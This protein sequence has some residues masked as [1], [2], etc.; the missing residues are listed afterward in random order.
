MK[1]LRTK[2]FFSVGT[3]LLLSSIINTIVSELW[4]RKELGRGGARISHYM[5]NAQNQAK[6]FASFLLSFRIIEQAADLERV[7]EMTSSSLSIE[8]TSTWLEAEKPLSYDPDIAF[9]QVQTKN[10][11]NAVIT[12][13]DAKL[14]PFSWAQG[15]DTTLWIK[16]PEEEGL[17]VGVPE[18]KGEETIYLLFEH[19]LL[20]KHLSSLSSSLLL[21]A[22][23]S[24]EDAAFKEINVPSFSYNWKDSVSHLFSSLLLYQ[25][26]WLE[27]LNLI[28]SLIP[29][30][31]IQEAVVPY[32]IAKIP[33]LDKHPGQHPGGCLLRKEL[34]STES[35]ILDIESKEQEKVPFL[36]LRNTP[37]GKD[38]DM[39]KAVLFS[40]SE[41]NKVVIGFSLSSLL[42]DVCQLIN[43]TII[44]SAENITIGFTP[45][46][47]TFNPEELDF[48]LKNLNPQEKL[49]TWQEKEYS[50]SNLNLDVFTLFILTP[51]EEALSMTNFLASIRDSISIKVTLSLIS[52]GLLSMLIALLFLHRIAKKI[53]GP[54]TV[55]SKASEELSK[56]VYEGLILPDIEKREDEVE[57]LANSFKG[58]VQAL[59]DRD[60]IR[61]V[62]N[63]VVSKEISEKILEGDIELEGEEKTLTLLFSDIRNFT[64]LAEGI[65]PHTLIKILNAYMTRMCHIIDE[66]HGVVD[67]FVGDE[68][69]TLYG[70]PIAFDF[71]A[72]KA[73]EAA[74]LMIKDLALWNETRRKEKEPVFEIGIGIH[75]GLVYTGNMGAENR[76]NYTA[77][78]SNVNEASRICSVAKPM[79][80]LISEET[81]QSPGV[82]EKFSCK[83]LE[84]VLLKGLEFPV[85]IYEVLS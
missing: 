51:E 3:I 43:K 70:A 77:I 83:K 72:V 68:I 8:N 15:P 37:S 36:F 78:G 46:G 21:A 48:P 41:R 52:A 5:E 63:K 69:M 58:M 26:E 62:L 18:V 59:K 67:K 80:I 25:N 57:I 24:P 29:W 17:F 76:L 32:G 30:Q 19:S 54:I 39:V 84:P 42:Q 1:T 31:M 40:N 35:L 71:H 44:A 55:L 65:P 60:K 22:N 10:N 20:K 81:Y 75:T 38:L 7:A 53:T 27:K 56:G 66:T 16:I 85:Q 28:Q 4:I 14:H 33:S 49:L 64:H 74:L 13:E 23:S 47:K 50:L 73:I 82:K 2:L 6:E 61:G 11:E 34:F 45:D 79:Q 9:I 12:L